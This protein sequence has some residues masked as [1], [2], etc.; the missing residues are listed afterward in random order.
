MLPLILQSNAA[1]LDLVRLCYEDSKNQACPKASAGK[2]RCQ[3][4]PQNHQAPTPWSGANREA[5]A[6]LLFILF[7]RQLILRL[8]EVRRARSAAQQ[9]SG[10]IMMSLSELAAQTFTTQEVTSVLASCLSSG[11]SKLRLRD[12]S[13]CPRSPSQEVVTSRT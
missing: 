7:I 3:N 13:P 10:D 11:I 12:V 6:P 5:V 1:K 8:R 9:A 2:G 4:Q